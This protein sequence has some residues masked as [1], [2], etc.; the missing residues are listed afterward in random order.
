MSSWFSSNA[1]TSI[2][3]SP[4][5]PGAEMLNVTGNGRSL[6]SSVSA[7]MVPLLD[8]TTRTERASCTAG[9]ASMVTIRYA[10]ECVHA[11]TT[12]RPTRKAR[13]TGTSFPEHDV[14]EIGRR[15]TLRPG[16]LVDRDA[17]GR[18]EDDDAG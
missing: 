8:S 18:A 7:R 10:S 4:E 17:A 11:A 16:H 1:S 5:R 3:R 6:R 14:A 2:A 9:R 13:R 15:W 12:T